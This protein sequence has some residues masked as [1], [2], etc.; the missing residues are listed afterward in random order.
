MKYGML[1]G[2]DGSEFTREDVRIGLALYCLIPVHL[3]VGYLIE[4][5]AS[6]HARGAQAQNKKD[7]N[8]DPKLRAA[9]VL[10]AFAHAI[11]ATLSLGITTSVVY[12]KIHHPLIGSL[13]QFHAGACP[14]NISFTVSDFKISYCMAKA[15]F[16]CIY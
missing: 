3:F 6:Q 13:C 4:L 9:W 5:V 16:I 10:I 1:I 8:K 15:A 11:N 2:F 7:D 12:W 14:K